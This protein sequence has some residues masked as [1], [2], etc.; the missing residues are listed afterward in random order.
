MKYIH[1]SI[2]LTTLLII[3]SMLQA[4]KDESDQRNIDTSPLIIIGQGTDDWLGYTP[5]LIDSTD[6]EG[7]GDIDLV[8]LYATSQNGWLMLFF[9]VG[10]E[11]VLQRSN[12][13]TLLIDSDHD[14]ATGRQTGGM[15]AEFSW[16]FGAREGCWYNSSG[17]PTSID[18]TDIVIR[19]APTFSSTQ[20]EVALRLDTKFDDSMSLV[21]GPDVNIALWDQISG[22]DR[23]PQ[24]GAYTV[25]VNPSLAVHIPEIS[26]ARNDSSHFRI[27]QHNVQEDGILKRPEYFRRIYQ[28]AAPDLLLLGEVYQ[29][30]LK[31][32]LGLIEEWLPID[33]EELQWK[34]IRHQDGSM[35][36]SRYPI[37]L[38]EKNTPGTGDGFL[39]QL[40]EPW[41][42]NLLVVHAWA[43]CC[44]QD[45]LRQVHCDQIIADIRDLVQDEIIT[46]D[47][48]IIL[49]GDFNLVGK[50]R[51]YETLKFGSISDTNNFG[52]S[53]V[54]DSYAESFIDLNPRSLTQAMDYTWR[55][56]SISFPPG[57]LD[58]IFYTGSLLDTGNNFIFDD[59]GLPDSIR[60]D[61][62]LQTG[63]C[64]Q[65][66]DHLPLVADFYFK[67]RLSK[68]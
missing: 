67:N 38:I 14:A 2:V 56:D 54:P 53:F 36:L 44:D 24:S 62:K 31:D 42:E 30:K 26:I 35:V 5:I 37:Q 22:G 57:R 4:C 60:D 29:A 33:S 32:V 27:L 45:S 23:M 63:D 3:Q 46:R 64:V 28:A 16:V 8:R 65:A 48:P 25:R 19:T 68:R 58:F 13:L 50:H 21:T 43:A 41:A 17:D 66:S 15:G 11:I 1:F 59:Q 12:T 52:P 6:S 18:Q 7:P 20:F 55:N 10:Q 51:N 40:P 9:E 39:L 34:A 47:T 61:Y 49:A